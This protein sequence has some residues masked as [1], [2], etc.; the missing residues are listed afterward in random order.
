MEDDGFSPTDNDEL[1]GVKNRNFNVF[2][3]SD[4]S[5]A[6]SSFIRASFTCKICLS[7]Q[8]ENNVNRL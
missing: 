6:T 1:K 2:A 4:D 3:L 7:L 8:K 5:C